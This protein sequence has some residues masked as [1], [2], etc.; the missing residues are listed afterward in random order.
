MSSL[1]HYDSLDCYAYIFSYKHNLDYYMYINYEY[2]IRVSVALSHLVPY[3]S[4]RVRHF[5]AI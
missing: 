2:G 1:R 5:D 4:Y 3:C